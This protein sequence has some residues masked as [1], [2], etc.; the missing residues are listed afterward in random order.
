MVRGTGRA[1]WDTERRGFIPFSGGKPQSG[2]KEFLTGF[3]LAPE[4][5]NLWGR[6]RDYPGRPDGSLLMSD[7]GGNRIWRISYKS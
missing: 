1:G 3:T 2:P 5:I 7:V 4:K 6:L